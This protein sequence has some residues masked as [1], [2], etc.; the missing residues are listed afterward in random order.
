MGFLPV[1]DKKETKSNNFQVK[2][3]FEQ[4]DFILRSNLCEKIH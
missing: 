1:Y 3:R 2:G 4:V